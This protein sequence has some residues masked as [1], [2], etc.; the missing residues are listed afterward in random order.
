MREAVTTSFF[1]VMSLILLGTSPFLS[2]TN[3]DSAPSAV[4]GDPSPPGYD[5]VTLDEVSAASVTGEAIHNPHSEPIGTISEVLRGDSGDLSGIVAEV[6]PAPN[7]ETRPVLLGP[8]DIR[9]YRRHDGDLAVYVATPRSELSSL[10]EY[11][12]EQN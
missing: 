12:P 1:A 9:I 2:S 5:P 3:A 10:P 11:R 6:A 4:R 7:E 8:E